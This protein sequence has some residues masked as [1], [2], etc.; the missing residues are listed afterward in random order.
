VGVNYPLFL[1]AILASVGLAVAV[2]R[3]VLSCVFH[4]MDKGLPCAFHWRPVIFA[5]SLF[6]FWYLA[7]AI[8]EA[9]PVAAH[10]R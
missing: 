6:W 7:P 4:L 5:A 10:L 3:A 2:A 8:A 1:I 9:I